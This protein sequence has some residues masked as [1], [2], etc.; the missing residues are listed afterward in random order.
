MDAQLAGGLSPGTPAGAR[1]DESPAG[2]EP[3][4]Q[5]SVL[6]GPGALRSVT[7]GV[8][9]TLRGHRGRRHRPE[10]L[11]A[12]LGDGIEPHERLVV[13]NVLL[14]LGWCDQGQREAGR[15]IGHRQAFPGCVESRA[16]VPAER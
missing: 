13:G 7:Q 8:D 5:H 12:E 6:P 9:G 1:L 14:G 3:G 16:T 10:L 4:R 2:V 11:D 15:G